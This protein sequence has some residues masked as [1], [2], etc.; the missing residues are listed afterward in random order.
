MVNA[1]R[2]ARKQCGYAV[3][4]TA[5]L[6]PVS[7]PC[8]RP[9]RRSPFFYDWRPNGRPSVTGVVRSGDRAT[10]VIVP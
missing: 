3:P 8:H 9:D 5:Q 1:P 2:D 4:V 7:R 10:T 6:W